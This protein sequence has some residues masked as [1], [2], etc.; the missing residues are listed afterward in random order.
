MKKPIK[1]T[2]I[3]LGIFV[4]L[5][6]VVIIIFFSSAILAGI[7]GGIGYIAKDIS[8]RFTFRISSS[9]FKQITCIRK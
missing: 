1:W 4:L 9:S 6:I 7:I 8:R 5:I 3:G 2:L